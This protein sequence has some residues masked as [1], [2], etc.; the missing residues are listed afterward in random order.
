[1]I[2][3][4]VLLAGAL[5]AAAA[6]AAQADVTVSPAVVSD[7]DFRGISQSKNDPAFQLGATYAHE[8]GFYVGAWGSNVDFGLDK[9]DIELDVTTGFTFGD[10]K[11][12]F[13]YDVGA[14][15]YTYVSASDF[16]FPEIYAGI[17]R[18]WFN[19]KLFY[20]WDFGGVK[21]SAYYL[22][23]TGTFPLPADFGLAVHAGYSGGN[24]WDTFY[25]N[26]YFDWSVGVT[27]ALGKFTLGLAF[28]DGS[29]LPTGPKNTPFSSA[30]KVV[31]TVTT[32]LPWA[33]E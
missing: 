9:P 12:G 15:Y 30:S 18:D 20:S 22:S 23:T 21:E 29:D 33:S 25:G 17:T 27:K 14:V 4:R 13:A 7:Y 6:G 3:S 16:N 24:Y 5:L 8:S 26:G 1:M 32:T 10:A 19:A 31:A 28:V 2:K 11:E